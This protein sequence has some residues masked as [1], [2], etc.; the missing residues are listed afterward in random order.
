MSTLTDAAPAGAASL[1]NLP[2][3]QLNYSRDK[4]VPE[5][6]NYSLDDDRLDAEYVLPLLWSDYCDGD[7]F[8]LTDYLLGITECVDVT[9][10]DGSPDKVFA[11]HHALWGDLVHHVAPA[12]PSTRNGKVAG[13]LTGIRLARHNA[14]ILADDDV[15]YDRRGLERMVAE[16]RSADV[17]R[18][19]N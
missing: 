5:R 18:P 14:V 16:L 3:K 8:E 12:G 9:I 19:Q 7:V 4:F 1:T 15:R 6:L 10:V 13:V 17:V 11:A 2:P